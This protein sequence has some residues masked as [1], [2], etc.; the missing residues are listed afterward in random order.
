MQGQSDHGMSIKFNHFNDWSSPDTV[1]KLPHPLPW[2]NVQWLV[3]C[4]LQ[5]HWHAT[6]WLSVD[7][8]TTGR[9]S[10]YL[11][12][13]L[14]HHWK[15]LIETTSHW[16]A[17]GAALLQPTLALYSLSGKTSYRKIS[18]SLEAARFGFKLYQSLSNL[19][20]T[21]AALLP[22]SLSN[23][24]AIRTWQYPISRLPDFTSFGGKT[25]YRLVNRVPGTPL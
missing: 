5:C 25:S 9:P 20:G 10:E 13:T 11:Q 19:A 22:R 7:C 14:G 24:R 3:Q 21:S 23:F 6:D 18:W 4:T 8:V 17:T 2:A 12:G 16:N 15:N 1:S